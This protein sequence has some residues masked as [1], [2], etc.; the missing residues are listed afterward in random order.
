[1]TNLTS[2]CLSFFMCNTETM[3]VLPTGLVLGTESTWGKTHT[4]PDTAPRKHWLCREET[5]D[6]HPAG[7]GAILTGALRSSLE[8]RDRVGGREHGGTG[9]TCPRLFLASEYVWG[10]EEEEEERQE[11]EVET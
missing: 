6:V 8:R 10:E 2:L 7:S 3:A 5:Y 1:M 4:V 11:E 9:C